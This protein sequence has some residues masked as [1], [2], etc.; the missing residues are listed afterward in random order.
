M[1]KR[2]NYIR[3]MAKNVPMIKI[4]GVRLQKNVTNYGTWL[5]AAKTG[6]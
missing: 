4:M 6:L 1:A 2:D 5:S 3:M